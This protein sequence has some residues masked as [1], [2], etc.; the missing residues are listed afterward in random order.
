VRYETIG[1]LSRQRHVVEVSV[2]VFDTSV[3]LPI[4]VRPFGTVIAKSQ[5][6]KSLGVSL[7]GIQ[8][9]EP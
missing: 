8:V 4:A 5:V 3:P 6:A 9:G 2:S 7:T 1:L